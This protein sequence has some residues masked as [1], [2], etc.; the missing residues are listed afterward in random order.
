M[1]T[2][3]RSEIIVG[4]DGSPASDRALRWAAGDA[5]PH[6]AKLT[7]VYVTTPPTRPGRS[8]SSAVD[9][10]PTALSSSASTDRPAT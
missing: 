6:G 7:I 8:S 10:T 9:P 2:V 4:F 5:D 3:N 1:R